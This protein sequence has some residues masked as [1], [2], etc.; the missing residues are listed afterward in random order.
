M[1]G[2]EDF[3]RWVFSLAISAIAALGISKYVLSDMKK[4]I[5]L[6]TAELIN[7]REAQTTFVSNAKLE[8]V[9]EKI[10]ADCKSS[11]SGCGMHLANSNAE[12]SKRLDQ[13]TDIITENERS[14]NEQKDIRNAAIAGLGKQIALLDK[15]IAVL[16]ATIK[17]RSYRYRKANG[18]NRLHELSEAEE[19]V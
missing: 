9:Q 4:T 18:V 3:M 6:H 1:T 14:R 5:D 7:I 17:L 15:N 16:D 19:E 12:V 10:K 11:Q 13:L 8:I 2:L